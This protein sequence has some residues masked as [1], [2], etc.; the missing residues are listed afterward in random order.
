MTELIHA[1]GRNFYRED[2]TRF[3]PVGTTVYAL[4]HQEQELREQ[5]METLKKTPL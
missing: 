4:I 1:E 2:G 5:T 3:V